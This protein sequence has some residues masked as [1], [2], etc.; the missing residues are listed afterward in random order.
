VADPDLFKGGTNNDTHLKKSLIWILCI[1]F[2]LVE[3][4]P[5]VRN[6][7]YTYMYTCELVV[8]WCSGLTSQLGLWLGG[9]AAGSIPRSTFV[10]CGGENVYVHSLCMGVGVHTALQTFTQLSSVTEG[11]KLC[12]RTGP[13]L[14]LK[15]SFLAEGQGSF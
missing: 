6:N 7:T 12:W 10:F 8:D 13:K 14:T 4:R 9:G 15:P 2:T 1:P 3:Q 11:F 5:D